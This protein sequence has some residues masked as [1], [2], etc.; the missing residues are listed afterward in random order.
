MEPARKRR[1]S[2]MWKEP[3]K[4][5]IYP[6]PSCVSCNSNASK[7]LYFEF[8]G[9]FLS[10]KPRIKLQSPD[11]PAPSCVS[12]KSDES[13]DLV[14]IFKQNSSTIKQTCELKSSEK[15]FHLEYT[16]SFVS[17][18]EDGQE[19]E[20]GPFIE[21]TKQFLVKDADAS[22]CQNKL[23]SA[24]KDR[25][26]CVAEGIV[27]EG[28]PL[29]LNKFYTD[30]Y[31]SEAWT[32]ELN[33]E[34]ELRYI[35]TVS[36]K[37]DGEEV[38]I[39]VE[40]LFKEP[41]PCRT[42][43]T[44]GVAGIG[45]TVLTQK[46]TLDWAEN[47]TNQSIH[48]IFPFTF[49]EL[50]VLKGKV[51]SLVE[52]VHYFFTETKEIY[53]FEEFQVIFIFDG[54]D[55]CRLPL[56]FQNN[57]ILNDV[58]E[59]ASLDVLLTNLIRGELL[60]CA[61]LWITTR[62]AAANQIPLDCIDMV[63]E[64]RGFAEQQK[65]EYFNKRFKNLEFAS[66]II[67]HT[68]TSR[69]LNVM[70]QIPVFCWI[71]ATVLEEVFKTQQAT[72]LP[73]TLTEMYIYHLLVQRKVKKYDGEDET[74][75]H[76]SPKSKTM[77]ESLGRLA[78]EQLQKGNLIFYESDLSECGISIK[79]A[80]EYSGM[81]TQIFKVERGWY[82]DKL[83]SFVHLSV[84]EFLAALY[85]H[86]TFT[87]LGVNLFK[88]KKLSKL[89]TFFSKPNLA[90]F[91]QSAVNETLQSPNGHL[92]LL[93]RFLLGLSLEKNLK[94]LKG[95]MTKTERS[96]QTNQEIVQYIKHKIDENL[97]TD[98]IMNLFHCLNELNDD[99]LVQE[100]QQFLSA[101]QLS[102]DKLSP[103][104]WSALVF[105]LL[106]SEREL[107]V[108]D[109]NMF[110]VSEEVVLRLLPV[111]KASKKVVLT[112]CV[113][114]QRSIEA[115]STV[116]KTKSSPLT[117]LDLSNNNLH[118]LG[119]KEI[120]DGLKS[121]N[122]TLRT[123]RLSGC[124]LSKQSV[125]HLLL[126]CNSFICL[127]EL[128]LSNN[129]L[130]DLTINKL[131][132]GLK[133]PLCQLETL[134]LKICCLSEMSCEALSALLSSESASLKEL[135]LSNNNLGDSG[136]KL[137]SAGLASSCCK[138]ETLRLS[139]C[140]VTEEGSA[141]LESAL[142]CNPSHLRELDLSYNHAGDFGVKGLCAN[143]KDPQWKLENLRLDP[144]GVKWLRPGL[145][146]Y[147]CN[148][149]FHT[150]TVN[151][152]VK[153]SD[154]NTEAS[155]VE[156]PQAYPDHPDRFDKNHQVMC[157]NS[158]TGRCYWEVELVG[159]VHTSVSYKGIVRRGEGNDGWF[160]GND[161]S[162]TLF[163]D[164]SSYSLWHNKKG[165][166]IPHMTVSSPSSHRIAVYLDWPMGTLSFYR[167]S[168]D[169]LIHIHTFHT[170]FTEPLYPG[171]GLWS[172]VNAPLGSSVRLI[173]L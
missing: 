39:R 33:K 32:R 77:L 111:I 55:E 79:D 64:V 45:K 13:K 163:Y 75:D 151:R 140:L 95:L 62:P 56:D 57:K 27:K 129:I 18:W 65:E 112:F 94:L 118:D 73:K 154:N 144:A 20:N 113:L 49:R 88:D 143:L 102:T 53:R 42:V 137:L 106:S 123:L 30:L 162:W 40:D 127:R 125:D 89:S 31:V 25:F 85:V 21:I 60:P 7:D 116:L 34:H 99:S 92:D 83:F 119:M 68:K 173:S 22:F 12:C 141:S 35:E 14:I 8:K 70:C 37:Q 87:N 121:P 170:T 6:G 72:E 84:Q 100:I 51:L 134:R 122:C 3:L 66:K 17:L 135:D 147:F 128:D 86:L 76:W 80:S 47:K 23:K 124:S 171:F 109:L 164:G 96:S 41:K 11:L 43:M 15:V 78:F 149:T 63:T 54:L 161:Q 138:L 58:T 114:S 167:V 132:D 120:A 107:D 4:R 166:S 133:H 108:F 172:W 169:T 59:S 142:N 10:P 156:E 36:R 145:R 46:F 115:L 101:G 91:Y 152:N 52:L 2:H 168:L 98:K 67:S 44:T 103:A 160:G 28:S 146:K 81:F 61:R 157:S 165:I 139:G 158:L 82:D 9:E 105:F 38:T 50:N 153:L 24:L 110:S 29:P 74:G 131:S 126:S 71:T 16:E 90:S 136:V 5:D 150:N 97:S 19:L 159:G 48:F 69:S 93:L 104:Q 148:L 1:I 155:Y 26:Q 130:Q 117:V